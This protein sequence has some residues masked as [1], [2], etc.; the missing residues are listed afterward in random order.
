MIGENYLQLAEFLKIKANYY[1]KNPDFDKLTTQVIAK[2]IEIKTFRKI[3]EKPFSKQEPSS[4]NLRQPA[5]C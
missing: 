3:P 2:Q 4:M 5:V 1:Q